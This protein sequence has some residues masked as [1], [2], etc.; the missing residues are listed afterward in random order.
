[1][2]VT[3]SLPSSCTATTSP[4]NGTLV[5]NTAGAAQNITVR[6]TVSNNP[7]LNVSTTPIGFVYQIGTAAPAATSITPA[8]TSTV[9]QY[10][11]LPAEGHGWW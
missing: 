7:L 2:N 6:L 9:L 5:L 8:S 1:V 11:V 4:C 10:T 3:V